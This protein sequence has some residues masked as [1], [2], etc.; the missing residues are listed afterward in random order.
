LIFT[1]ACARLSGN[2]AQLKETVRGAARADFSTTPAGLS[3]RHHDL[4][5]ISGADDLRHEWRP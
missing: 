4:N 1:V 3:V 2:H 5:R